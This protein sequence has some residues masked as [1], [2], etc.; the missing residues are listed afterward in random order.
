MRRYSLALLAMSALTAAVGAG[1]KALASSHR[2]APAIASDS[3]ADNNDVYAFMSPENDGTVTL[4]ATYVPLQEPMGGPNYYKFGDDVLYSIQIDNNGDALPDIQYRFRF[5]STTQNPN[6][7]LYNTGTITSLTDPDFNVRQTYGVWRVDRSGTTLLGRDLMVPP[8]NIGPQSTPNYEALATQ[9]IATLSDGST[10]FAGQRDD[11]FFVDL[12]VFDLLAIRA[13]VG[14]HGGGVD[15]LGGFNC[16]AIVLKV[17][18]N[19]LTACG[20][21]PSGSGDPNAVIGVWASASRR[22][23]RVLDSHDGSTDDSGPWV[24]VS[25]LGM[26]LVNEVVIPLGY[27]DVWNSSQPKDDAQ[28]LPYVDTPELAGLLNAIYGISVPPSPRVDLEQV[29]LTGVPGLNQPQNVVPSEQIRMNVAIAAYPLTSRFG[30]IGGDLGGFPNGRRLE[31]DVTD[32]SLRAVAGVLVPGF[33]DFPNNALGDGIDAN[34]MPFL[35]TFPYLASPHQG[36]VHAHHNEQPISSAPRPSK[37][38][39]TRRAAEATASTR[40]PARLLGAA[41]SPF[42]STTRISF[43][44]PQSGDADLT[45]FDVTGRQVRT[46]Y[47]GALEAGQHDMSWD[48]TN[49]SGERVSSGLY[50]YRLRSESQVEQKPIMVQR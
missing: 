35:T 20:C 4:V 19:R 46:L 6:T 27:K 10:V 38:T 8:V 30:V 23:T 14:D 2:E 26:P 24:E 9:A 49:A 48:A 40:V 50:F 44:L 47:T 17:P 28:F 16:Q 11:P 22:T 39:V 5:N 12:G 13:P 41:P 15:G 42:V 3:N 7:F 21:T 33:G 34:D 1:T 43:S 29:F 25:R 45:I 32:V 36:F 37:S 18:V 31:D